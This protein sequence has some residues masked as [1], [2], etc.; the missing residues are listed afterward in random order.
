LRIEIK[1]AGPAEYEPKAE[2]LKL[3]PKSWDKHFFVQEMRNEHKVLRDKQTWVFVYRL[4]P[5]HTKVNA[6]QGIQLSYYFYDPQNL[7]ENQY[8]TEPHD[9]PIAITVRPR[10]DPPDP[11]I[12]GADAV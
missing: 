8:R 9:D 3:F 10:P 4:R 12:P 6:I 11:E 5:K 2:N 7:E 1:G